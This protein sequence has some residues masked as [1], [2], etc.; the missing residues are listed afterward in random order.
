MVERREM[1]A[2]LVGA[3]GVE[4][5]FEERGRTNA[6]EGAPVG[7]SFARAGKD[8]AAAG[9][10]PDAAPGVAGDGEVD[11]AGGGVEMAFDESDVGLFD[12]AIA[13]GFAEFGV[14]EVVFGDEDDPGGLLVEAMDDA[15]A[16][17]VAAL[18]ERLAATEE[19]V[20]ERAGVV[21]GAGGE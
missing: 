15:G 16:E 12:F 20:D 11:D 9:G 17:D 10:H 7:A 19:R 13:E 6:S 8:E 1:D 18:R 21:S 5:D 4:L 2:D 14:S 3:A